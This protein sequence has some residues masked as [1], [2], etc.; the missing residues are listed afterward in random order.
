MQIYQSLLIREKVLEALNNITLFMY[1]KPENIIEEIDCFISSNEI[2]VPLIK[3][4][5]AKQR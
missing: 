3:G 1:L 2:S 4:K 5:V